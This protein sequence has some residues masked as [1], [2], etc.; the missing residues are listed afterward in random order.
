MTLFVDKQDYGF[1][2]TRLRRYAK[3]FQVDLLSYCIMPNH[4][5]F[6]VKAGESVDSLTKMMQGLQTSYAQYFNKR[7]KHFGYVFQGRYQRKH[8]DSQ[9]YLLILSCY[10]HANPVTAGIVAFGDEWQYSSHNEYCSGLIHKLMKD[11]L[12][13]LNYLE[14]FQEYLKKQQERISYIKNFL[15]D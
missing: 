4:Y 3:E 2:V 6:L 10:I 15:M 1:F 8:V 13:D 5:H 14:I 11:E 9:Q 7:Y 12:V